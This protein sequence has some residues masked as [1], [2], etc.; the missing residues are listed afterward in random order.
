[1]EP[2]QLSILKF[3]GDPIETSANPEDTVVSVKEQIAELVQVPVL[4][5]KLWLHEASG[6][7]VGRTQPLRKKRMDDLEEEFQYGWQIQEVRSFHCP[8]Q[9]VVECVHLS[10]ILLCASSTFEIS[11]SQLN[12]RGHRLEQWDVCKRFLENPVEYMSALKKFSDDIC[13]GRLSSDQVELAQN[14]IEEMGHTFSARYFQRVSEFCSLLVR[15]VS[16]ALK[17][18]HAVN[19][20]DGPLELE[21]DF[22]LSVY[23]DG[24]SLQLALVVDP[25]ALFE[26]MEDSM[27]KKLEAIAALKTLGAKFPDRALRELGTALISGYAE[28]RAAALDAIK[29]WPANEEFATMLHNEI[30]IFYREPCPKNEVLAA[31]E[32]LGP[33]H[34]QLLKRVATGLNAGNC[35]RKVSPKKKKGKEWKPAE[36]PD[37]EFCLETFKR[38][39]LEEDPKKV[40]DCLAYAIFHPAT[41]RANMDIICQALSLAASRD[42]D[43]A[44]HT[45]VGRAQFADEVEEP[46]VRAR[47]AEMA[48]CFAVKEDEKVLSILRSCTDLTGSDLCTLAKC[49]A[50]LSDGETPFLPILCA[51]LPCGQ[52]RREVLQTIQEMKPV[53]NEAVIKAIMRY[54]E[55]WE[56]LLSCFGPMSML[57]ACRVMEQVAISDPSPLHKAYTQLLKALALRLA[58]P[59]TNDLYDLQ[60]RRFLLDKAQEKGGANDEV[61]SCLASGFSSSI[62]PIRRECLYFFQKVAKSPDAD[63]VQV[64]LEVLDDDFSSWSCSTALEALRSCC[65]AELLETRA[66][67]HLLKLLKTKSNSLVKCAALKALHAV[68]NGEVTDLAARLARQDPIDSVRLAALQLLRGQEAAEVSNLAVEVLCTDS[69]E[70]VLLGALEVLTPLSAAGSAGKAAV[71]AA[72]KLLI[73]PSRQVRLESARLLGTASHDAASG[74]TVVTMA[75]EALQAP[76]KVGVWPEVD[77]EILSQKEESAA[78]LRAL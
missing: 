7:Q 61:L 24:S 70:T 6:E 35:Q 60:C 57:D 30:P 55:N 67:R 25:E 5:Q 64:L 39:Q 48:M 4:C 59:R 73:H 40:L 12:V 15:W 51:D 38:L 56:G 11:D 58:R 2:I 34:P 47:A 14:K 74:V 72:K 46:W 20:K 62:E 27:E 65:D 41:R 26:S 44:V 3:A 18:Y 66:L 37:E 32:H 71:E 68:H 8:P 69:S 45:I 10:L 76:A 77:A 42:Y 23:A 53:D 16:C 78:A 43:T 1:M 33:Q 63:V 49:Y 17:L 36:E 28:L 9:G 22:Q 31:L 21:D 19:A 29:G 50:H 13:A 75:L 52:D 54:L